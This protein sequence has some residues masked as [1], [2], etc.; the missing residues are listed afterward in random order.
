MDSTFPTSAPI[1]QYGGHLKNCLW[2][3][4]DYGSFRFCK[5][6]YKNCYSFNVCDMPSRLEA[7]ARS[8]GLRLITIQK[9]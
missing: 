5:E 6:C 8:N 3:H 1:F 2:K 7:T 4:P 9:K